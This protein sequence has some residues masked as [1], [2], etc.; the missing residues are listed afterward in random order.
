[1]DKNK[2][3]EESYRKY[4]SNLMKW[5]PE[6]IIIVDE[7]MLQELSLLDSMRSRNPRLTSHF[8]IMESEEKI[9]LF[10]ESFVIWIVPDK[11]QGVG[12]TYTLIALNQLE[13]PHLELAF[14]T[15]GRYNTSPWILMVLDKLL[16]K[17]QENEEVITNLK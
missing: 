15:T 1:M 6:G 9:T 12:I 13:Q 14:A 17:I 5:L 7:E 10:N 3:F 16:A 2:K 11:I 8:Q 4:T